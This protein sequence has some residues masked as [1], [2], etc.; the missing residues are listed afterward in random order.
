ML[1][2]RGEVP[3]FVPGALV[4]TFRG[5]IPVPA[6]PPW[7]SVLLQMVGRKPARRSSTTARRR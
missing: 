1:A 4:L 5:S 3:E 2:P 7:E 6:P